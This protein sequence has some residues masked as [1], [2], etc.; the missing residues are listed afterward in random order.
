MREVTGG[1]GDDDQSQGLL[2]FP[3]KLS[4]NKEL[5]GKMFLD[6]FGTLHTYTGVIS[7]VKL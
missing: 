3:P 5:A 7:H 4:S 1:G 2:I 6:L